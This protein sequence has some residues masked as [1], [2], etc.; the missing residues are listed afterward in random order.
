MSAEYQVMFYKA[1]L[2]QYGIQC[3]IPKIISIQPKIEYTNDEE[4]EIKNVTNFTAVSLIQDVHQCSNKYA[5]DTKLYVPDTQ[6]LTTNLD[7]VNSNLAK[8][9]PGYQMT[10][11]VQRGTVTVEYYRKKPGFVT[12]FSKTEMEN[13]SSIKGQFKFYDNYRK[14]VI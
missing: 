8:V 4:L 6:T 9:F 3:D 10:R 1:I 12:E 11:K 5:G 14:R 13:N 2:E 7:T